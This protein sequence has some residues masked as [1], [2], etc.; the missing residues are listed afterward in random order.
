M[1]LR[2]GVYGFTD[3]SF[4]QCKQEFSHDVVD[5]MYK[6]R[7]HKGI[8]IAEYLHARVGFSIKVAE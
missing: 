4:A 7:Q 6:V 8:I 5:T 1:W 2:D 3:D